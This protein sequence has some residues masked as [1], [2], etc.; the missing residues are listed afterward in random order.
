MKMKTAVHIPGVRE[1][2]LVF[3][4]HKTLIPWPIVTFLFW[5]VG[6]GDDAQLPKVQTTPFNVR[7]SLVQTLSDYKKIVI[8][9]QK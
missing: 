8:G 3:E 7:T 6:Y 9:S 2:V 4:T 5:Q 1:K